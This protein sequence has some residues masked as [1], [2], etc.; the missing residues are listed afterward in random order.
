MLLE[1]RIDAMCSVYVVVHMQAMCQC[2]SVALSVNMFEL[3]VAEKLRLHG[4]QTR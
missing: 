4:D 1:S 2:M 3:S